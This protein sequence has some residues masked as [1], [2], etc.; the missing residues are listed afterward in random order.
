MGLQQQLQQPSSE[1]VTNFLSQDRQMDLFPLPSLQ[2]FK[3]LSP[4][5]AEQV[6]NHLSDKS[7]RQCGTRRHGL[8][9]ANDIIRN[10]DVLSDHSFTSKSPVT[11]KP[12][13][14]QS[15]ALSHIVNSVTAFGAP[16]DTN[17]TPTEALR[18]LRVSHDYSDVRKNLAPLDL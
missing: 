11:S 17:L 14:S 4:P 8:S 1:H 3:G 9:D 15:K 7:R 2:T 10:L 16:P 12:S 18:E 6:S 5:D 13:A